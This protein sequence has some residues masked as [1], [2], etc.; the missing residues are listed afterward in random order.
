MN[1]DDVIIGNSVLDGKVTEK[2]VNKTTSSV[3]VTRTKRGPEGV[4]CKQWFTL[5]D[6]EKMFNVKK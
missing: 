4:S 5:A 6:F 2:I 1:I 3:E